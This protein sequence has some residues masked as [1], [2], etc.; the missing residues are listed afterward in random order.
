MIRGYDADISK[1]NIECSMFFYGTHGTGSNI[2]VYFNP[3]KWFPRMDA[4]VSDPVKL[5]IV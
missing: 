3:N 1:K 2:C 4:N 5:K